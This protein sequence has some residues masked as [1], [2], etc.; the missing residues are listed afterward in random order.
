MGRHQKRKKG[1]TFRDHQQHNVDGLLAGNSPLR[2]MN[3]RSALMHTN[4]RGYFVRTVRVGLQGPG[5]RDDVHVSGARRND[6]NEP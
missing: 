5:R 3:W 6:S 4:R 2:L 1:T